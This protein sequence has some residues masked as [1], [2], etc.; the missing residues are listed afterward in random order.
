MPGVLPLLPDAV[1]TEGAVCR[2]LGLT[3]LAHAR[4]SEGLRFARKGQ[5]TLYLGRW[6]LA[7]L[8]GDEATIDVAVE[9]PG[10]NP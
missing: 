4:K 7:W 2:A 5:K 1:Y 6:L 3:S 10:A 8:E 9:P